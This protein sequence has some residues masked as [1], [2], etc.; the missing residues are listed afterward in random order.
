MSELL[1]CKR[2]FNP[3]DY[4]GLS[5][6]E[7]ADSLRTSGPNVVTKVKRKGFFRKFLENFGDPMI[8]IL[9]LALGINLIF[10]FQSSDWFETL[11]IAA[12]ILAVTLV[13]TVSEAGSAA[14][15]EK[16]QQEAAKIRCRV[17]R[18]GETQH[19]WMSELVVGD[20]VLLSAGD[21]VPADGVILGGRLDVDQSALNGETKEAHKYPA[22]R[23]QNRRD[24][25]LSGELL[26]GGTVVVGGEGIMRISH[27]GDQTYYGRIAAELQE[28]TPISPLKRQL[29]RTAKKISLFG[30]IGAGLVCIAYLFSAVFIQ[31]GFDFAKIGLFFSD[32]RA[33]LA[34]LLKGLTLAVSV[35]VMAVPEGLPMMI[36]VVLS[37]NMRRM[38]RDNV[39]VRR[40]NG[41][42]TAGSMNIL[43]SDKTGTLTAGKP[44]VSDLVLGGNGRLSARDACRDI[45]GRLSEMLCFSLAL[46][47]GAAM[48]DGKAV[49]GNA[50]DR[51][52]LSYAQRLPGERRFAQ[53]GE[54]L[55][56]TSDRKYMAAEMTAGGKRLT[57]FKGAPEKILA[58]CNR[59]L[60]AQGQ[61]QDLTDKKVLY[62][63]V[64]D[65]NG[66][67][68][69]VVAAAYAEQGLRDGALPD[70]MVLV[71]L[72]GIRDRVRREAVV[73]VR[74]L[75]AAGIQ[76][77][78]ITGDSK[79]TARAVAQEC[80][81]VKDETELVMTSE[82]LAALSDADI[83]KIL[84]KLRVVARALPGDKSRLVRIARDLSLVT[85][86]T[87]DGINDAP[88]LKAADV[89]FSMGSGAEVAK[90]A[91][92]IVILDDNFLS[93]VKAVSY[94]RTI[95]KSIRKFIIFQ[96]TVNFSA[97]FISVVA[98]FLGIMSPITVTQ[99]LWINLVMDTLGGL[100][101]S[102]ERPRPE[103]L[104][105]APKPLNDP[106][107]NPYMW[108][109]IL[110]GSI[111]TAALCLSFLNSS[112]LRFAF[113]FLPENYMSTAFFS[114]F[115]F[116]AIFSSLNAR[117]HRLS[118]A[119]NLKANKQ[120]IIIMSCI[121]FIQLMLI[122]VGGPLAGT[123][124]L[125]PAHF[126]MVVGLAFT[127]VPIDLTRKFI[128][129]KCAKKIKPGT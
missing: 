72:V 48:I 46:N 41:I 120:F 13:S 82:E 17:K 35:I 121:A 83:K 128:L 3:G 88:A 7:V 15:F 52:L 106:L 108:S 60:D 12:T 57:L 62:D 71:A 36:T 26:F 43:F 76:T 21:R 89:G 96:I 5:S 55:P 44:E 79:L 14:A 22:A 112:R 107:I 32:W 97:V 51:A 77:V 98:P 92:D 65:L 16:L 114:L 102:G 118:I 129:K 25:L 61:P 80:G 42:E 29:E 101:Y 2:L 1:K 109:E 74:Q 47:N 115:M 38:F 125:H 87:G 39:L 33:V 11:G 124:P 50:T 53:K 40:L 54:T 63:A 59:F 70:G 18:D 86:M 75:Q 28:E 64:A 119:S 94:G 105:E 56:F 19:I 116:A 4:R 81:I 91:G 95:Y 20:M 30:Y 58:F 73:G 123:A 6:G 117:T 10:L 127:V 34:H 37:A 27:V 104:T 78:M 8:R 69:R 45:G 23:T 85:G 90:E 24:D 110:T 9:L 111:Y 126:F 113:A 84:S 93:I 66:R 49:G 99:M 67:S 31:N 68:V 100:A 103:Y 122:Y